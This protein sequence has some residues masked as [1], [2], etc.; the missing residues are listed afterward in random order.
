MKIKENNRKSQKTNKKYRKSQE[1]NKRITKITIIT[2][3]HNTS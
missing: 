2:E 1:N 3:N